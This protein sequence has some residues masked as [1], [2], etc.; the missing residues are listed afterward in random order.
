MHSLVRKYSNV[1]S[2]ILGD[3]GDIDWI[4]GEEGVKGREFL[5]LV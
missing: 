3:H 1:T 2:V 5:D 4:T